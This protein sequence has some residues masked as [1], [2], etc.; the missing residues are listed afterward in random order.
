MNRNL[1][2]P[3][4]EREKDR[5]EGLNMTKQ[6]AIDK[7]TK[8]GVKRAAKRKEA[9]DEAHGQ[10]VE[11]R[12][13]ASAGDGSSLTTKNADEHSSLSSHAPYRDPG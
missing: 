5:K 4:V 13:L 9:E 11:G 7:G 6:E 3:R 2:D 8:D 1:L 12:S 10:A